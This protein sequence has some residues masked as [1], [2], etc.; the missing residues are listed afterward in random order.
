MNQIQNLK[1][2]KG[3]VA[4]NTNLQRA[5]YKYLNIALLH[6]LR[7]DKRMPEALKSSN[8]PSLGLRVIQKT[9]RLQWVS[10]LFN[11]P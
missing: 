7:T 9:I 10:E 4:E 1:A 11:K 2:D 5:L 8:L 6:I 3:R